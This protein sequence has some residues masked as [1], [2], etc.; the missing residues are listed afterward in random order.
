MIVGTV[1]RIA[2]VGGGDP[3]TVNAEYDILNLR[4]ASG[5]P[6]VSIFADNGQV[7]HVQ[8]DGSIFEFVC[9]HTMKKVI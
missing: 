1:K 6:S 2:S 5:V 3:F 7:A 9:L 4:D 8:V